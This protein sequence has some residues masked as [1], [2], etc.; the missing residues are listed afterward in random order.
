VLVTTFLLVVHLL[1]LFI[2]QA[3]KDSKRCWQGGLQEGGPALQYRVLHRVDTHVAAW[4]RH[5]EPGPK[6]R[7]SLVLGP[8]SEHVPARAPPPGLVKPRC[9]L[10]GV[11]GWGEQQQGQFREVTLPCLR[12]P[13]PTSIVS[14]PLATFAKAAGGG[15]EQEVAAYSAP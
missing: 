7:L 4:L 11:L 1:E 12:A 9:S 10:P 14:H 2:P 5:R 15:R 3:H 13:A 6:L 8:D